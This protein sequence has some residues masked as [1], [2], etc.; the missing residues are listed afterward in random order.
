MATAYSSRR[1][2]AMKKRA[3][4]PEPDRFEVLNAGGKLTDRRTRGDRIGRGKR[5]AD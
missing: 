3:S 2:A 1:E 5:S 4:R